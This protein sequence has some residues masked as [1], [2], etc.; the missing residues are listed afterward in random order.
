MKR[1]AAIAF[2]F[3]ALLGCWLS[4]PTRAQERGS[5]SNNNQDPGLTTNIRD[6][7]VLLR[8]IRQRREAPPYSLF[9]TSPLTPL[10]ERTLQAEKRIYEATDIKLGTTL[11]T[12]LQGLSDEMPGEDDFGMATA[13]S[14]VGT[15]DGYNKGEPKQGELTFELQGRWDWGTRAPNDLGNLGLG[16]LGFTSNQ[17][18][19]YTPTFLVRNLFWR[20][21]SREAGWM[22]R[23]GRI[24]PDAMLASSTH[25]NGLT[26]F[27]PI[28]GT[29]PFAMG[30]SDSG[31][32]IVAGKFVNDR[33]NV[34]GI[35]S[36]ANADRFDFGDIDEGDFFTAVEFQVKVLPLSKNAGYSTVSFWHNDGTKF[37]QDSNGSTGKEGW[38]LFIKHEQELTCDG[39]AIAIARWGRSYREVSAL[40]PTS[41]REFR[42]L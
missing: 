18:A 26:T 19:A 40:R 22:Y 33:V 1:N 35:V 4:M 24:T 39:R 25:I 31:L 10:R 20:Q 28:S 2:T 21:G 5:A 3:V 34:L 16:S 15:W 30:I 27:L 29:G 12:L 8:T 41:W 23:I 9:P 32:G 17:F 42:P 7:E 14:M 13:M 37:G 36:D 38:G 6:P 11:T